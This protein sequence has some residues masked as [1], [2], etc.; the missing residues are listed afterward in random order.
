MN[1]DADIRSE[2]TRFQRT[3]ATCLSILPLLFAGQCLA[4]VGMSRSAEGIF[5][6]FGTKLPI[7]TQFAIS[8]RPLWVVVAVAVPISAIVVSRGSKPVRSVI[9]STVCGLI[10]FGVAQVLAYAMWAP[11]V[12]LG[13][14]LSK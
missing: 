13:E 7:V 10:L 6:E 2:M 14:V 12:Q 1:D 4:A 3:V 8:W 9:F 5:R 11:I